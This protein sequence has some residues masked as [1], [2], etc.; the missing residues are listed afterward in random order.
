MKRKYLLIIMTLSML[1]ACC[2][3][4]Y[5][6]EE[7]HGTTL[8]VSKVGFSRQSEEGTS[9]SY[10]DTGDEVGLYAYIPQGINF[11]KL[12][13]FD[14]GWT[15]EYPIPLSGEWTDIYACYPY[16][17]QNDTPTSFEI[18]HHSQTDYL[19]SD[20]HRVNSANPVLSLTM[21]HALALI[22][23]EFEWM[24]IPQGA[25]LDFISIEGWSLSSRA[26][27][28]LL[29]GEMECLKGWNEPAIIYGWQL[30]NSYLYEGA[31]VSLMVVPLDKLEYDG[32]ILFNFYMD[33]LKGHWPVPAGTTWESGKKYTYKVRIQ[34]RKLE[35]WDV[36]IDDW[37][38]AGSKKI[39]LPYY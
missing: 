34:G 8:S 9:K 13:C 38:D 35:I 27:L 21:I 12:T 29:T 14:T 11:H 5:W 31:K 36:W 20:M 3:Q 39:T 26:K 1:C 6:P 7:E 16:D 30:N 15:L 37:I 4:E 17:R 18:E 24:D 32:N 22:E 19:Y 2:E 25:N 33:G 23:F 28:N 10:F